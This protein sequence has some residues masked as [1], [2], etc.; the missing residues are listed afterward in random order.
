MSRRG[1]PAGAGGV[2]VV[3]TLNIDH[4][5]RVPALPKPGETVLALDAIRQWGGKGANQAVA[6]ARQGARVTIVGAVGDDADGKLYC[7]HL[8]GEQI[9]TTLIQVVAGVATGTAHVYVD[10]R[11]ENQIVVHGG[12]NGRLDAAHV[13]SALGGLWAST[14]IVA[15]GL[16]CPLEPATVALRCAAARGVRTILNASPV[17]EKFPW[18]EFEIETVIVNEH[19]CVAVFGSAPDDWENLTTDQ[20]RQLLRAKSVR[21]IIVTQGSAPTLHLSAEEVRSVPTFPV[22]P[23]DTVGA[24]DTFAGTLAARLAAGAVWNDAIRHANVAA[25]LSTL[26]PGAQAGIP[27]LAAV[28]AAVADAPGSAG[29]P[30]AERHPA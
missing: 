29:A 20:R 8:A 23:V 11:G 5:W 18:G 13:S 28:E 9:A 2:V 22:Q 24:G 26:T 10:G 19:E 25:A 27:R 14:D 21:H 12:A 1:Q 6:A 30:P 17:N 16:E 7:D 15:V 4:V 3:G